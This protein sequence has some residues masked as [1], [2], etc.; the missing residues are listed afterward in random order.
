M[1]KYEVLMAGTGGQGLV[2]V[3]AFLAEAGILAGNNVVQTQTYGISQRGGFISAEV[4][5]DKGEILFQQ[6]SIPSVVLVLSDVVGKRYDDLTMPIV[7]DNS[8]MKPCEKSNWI[9]IPCSSIAKEAGVPKAA[10]LVGLGA[11]IVLCPIIPFEYLCQQAEKKMKKD[12]AER[13]IEAIKGGMKAAE[14]ALAR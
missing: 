4:L 8:L 10:N 11:M 6:V 1:A 3:A 12:I 13:N 9:G 5:L 14:A 7:Y 2:F